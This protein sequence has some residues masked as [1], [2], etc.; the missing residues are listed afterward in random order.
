M[1]GVAKSLCKIYLW[2]KDAFPTSLLKDVWAADVWREACKKTGANCDSFMQP[3]L[4]SLIPTKMAYILDLYLQFPDNSM[5]LFVET[6]KGLRDAVKLY[7]D[8]G[9]IPSLPIISE[10]TSLAS[11]LLRDRAFVYLVCPSSLL[12]IAY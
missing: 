8:F 7:Y 3:E 1:I 4:A 2:C 6:K 11:R 5:E 9:T 10:N 12:F